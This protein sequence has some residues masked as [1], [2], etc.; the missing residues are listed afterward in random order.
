[1]SLPFDRFQHAVEL[2]ARR[3]GQRIGVEFGEGF[4]TREPLRVDDL[5][6]LDVQFGQF[7]QFGQLT[8]PA[9]QPSL[10]TTNC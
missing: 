5:L 6:S 4:L 1:M 3:H 7:G 10:L 9:R 2:T 8:G